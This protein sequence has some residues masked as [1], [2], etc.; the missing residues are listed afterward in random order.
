[1]PG[2]FHVPPMHRKFADDASGRDVFGGLAGTQHLTGCRRLQICTCEDVAHRPL[3]SA[4]V[5]DITMPPASSG[6]HS[7]AESAPLLVSPRG[8][9]AAVTA[10]A[11]VPLNL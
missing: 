2:C 9:T 3:T 6:L 8:A 7:A 1:M 4:I 5:C 11:A 10:D